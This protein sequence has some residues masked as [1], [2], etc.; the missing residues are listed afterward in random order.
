MQ[1]LL[2]L[3]VLIPLLTLPLG[4]SPTAPTNAPEDYLAFPDGPKLLTNLRIIDGS[5]S[6][7]LE[8]MDLLI[9]DGRIAAVGEQLEAEDAVVID[10][11]GHTALP[12]LIHM[13]DHMGY[14]S[15]PFRGYDF[16]L[17][18]PHPFSIPKLVLAAGVTTVRTAGTDAIT[19]DVGLK[20]DIERGSAVGP[21]LMLTTPVAEGAMAGLIPNLVSEADGREFVRAH[22]PFGVEVVKTYAGV[23]PD[24]LRGVIA[25]A[26]HH[27]LHVAGHLGS[28]TSCA[29]AAIMGIDTIEHSFNSCI[30]DVPSRR[31]IDNSF[32]M[33]NELERVD[34]LIQTLVEN[35]VVMVTTPSGG[36]HAD[37]SEESL[38]VL[39]P[40]MREAFERIGVEDGNR[41]E[42]GN[43][44]Y[45]LTQKDEARKLEQRFVEA[46]GRLLIGA[47]AMYL[48][49]IP[50]TANHD[51][52]IEL[53]TVFSP[54]EVIRMA[55]SDAA[56]FLGLD[57]SR[58]R[59]AEGLEADLLIVNGA[60]DQD[61]RQI[62][63]VAVVF[64]SG[65][66]YDPSL[67][68][69]AARG[70]VGLD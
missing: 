64:R 4:L 2:G 54:L 50:G 13:H 58:G 19:I 18:D 14:M 39:A 40:H 32:Q 5:G 66:A 69:A 20:R 42:S 34:A 49:I 51:V 45:R 7:A 33:E 38:S 35:E 12:G 62:R 48:P 44:L 37:F 23:P 47:D 9:R 3:V 41:S 65:R 31:Y 57:G 52:M 59:I 8:G 1:K 24:A 28:G 15:S 27:G 43:L 10:Y 53:A 26:H 17:L 25:E 63:N 22:L 56:D 68:R 61:M 16:I 29:Q 67:L 60:P 36:R 55:T 6:P 30:R 21:Y 70:R 11:A 46:G